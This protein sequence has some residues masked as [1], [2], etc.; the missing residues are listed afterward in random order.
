MQSL[1]ENLLLLARADAGELTSR[2]SSIDL[3]D[4]VEEC[5]STQAD[6]AEERGLRVA[7]ELPPHCHVHGDGEF[8]RIVVAN[9]LDNGVSHANAGGEIS[10]HMRVEVEQAIFEVSNTGCAVSA[11]DLP[12]VFDRFWRGDVSRSQ[13]GRHAGLGLS[14]CQRLLRMLGGTIDVRVSPVGLFTARVTLPFEHHPL[15]SADE[16][17]SV[18]A[19]SVPKPGSSFR[20]QTAE[21]PAPRAE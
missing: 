9:L 13:T 6:R 1:V 16:P 3:V 10:L 11:K 20:P 7:R 15:F 19:V 17:A 21:V 18:P 4:L 14:L 12:H 8:L 2:P 5:W